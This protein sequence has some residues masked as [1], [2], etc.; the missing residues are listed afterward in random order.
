MTLSKRAKIGFNIWAILLCM[1]TLLAQL[2]L[3]VM[4]PLNLREQQAQMVVNIIKIWTAVLT[5]VMALNLCA[6]G[7]AIKLQKDRKALSES[8]SSA[9][10]E[11]LISR[12]KVAAIVIIIAALLVI[13]TLNFMLPAFAR[14]VVSDPRCET[15]FS[16]VALRLGIIA[17]LAAFATP[18][19]FVSTILQERHSSRV[20]SN[21]VSNN[22]V[23]ASSTT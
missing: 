17:W 16:G 11:R 5:L 10:I 6:F 2:P 1:L 15:T 18:L 14:T 20:V 4:A 19:W 13:I 22:G 8:A 3:Y 12:I 9:N 7:L 21:K 23:V